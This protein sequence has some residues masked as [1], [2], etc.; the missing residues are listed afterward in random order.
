MDGLLPVHRRA[1]SSADSHARL[2]RCTFTIS[3]ILFART[4]L[5]PVNRAAVPFSRYEIVRS[6][7]PLILRTQTNLWL[8]SR[9][10]TG[11]T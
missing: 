11:N 7:L 5:A 1:T 6:G 2:T 3:L 4:P 8:S 10:R 9:S